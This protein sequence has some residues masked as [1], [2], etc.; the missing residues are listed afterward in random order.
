ML[1]EATIVA[2]TGAP[3]EAEVDG[4]LVALDVE[5]GTCYGLNPTATRIWRLLDQPMPLGQLLDALTK[6]YD[7]QR[8]Q[9]REEVMAL[10]RELEADRLVELRD[11]PHPA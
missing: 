3:I 6:A 8:E 9:C 10:L 7:V 1:D 2:R 5:S 11:P 4:E